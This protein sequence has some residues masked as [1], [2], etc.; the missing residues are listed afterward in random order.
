[1]KFKIKSATINDLKRVQELNLLLFE[2]E[3]AEFDDTLNC[4]WTFGKEGTEYFKNRIIKDDGC[5]FVA[6]VGDEIVGYLAGGIKDNKNNHRL[7]PKFAELE[8]MFVLDRYRCMGVGS[9]LY[10]V[11]T[12]WCKSKGVG[13]LRVV[14]SAQNVGAI[15]FYR[16]KGFLDYDLV[17]ETNL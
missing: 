8:N 5:I 15:N 1:M 10:Q 6:V 2:K 4:K 7:L 9:N 17:L 12:D 13:R 11:F 3:Y 14:A 16:K